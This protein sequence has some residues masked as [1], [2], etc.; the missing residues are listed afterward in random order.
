MERRWPTR[1][2][3]STE[4]FLVPQHPDGSLA[5]WKRTSVHC[6]ALRIEAGQGTATGDGESSPFFVVGSDAFPT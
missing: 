2:D 6:T 5:N 1:S 3:G 4:A